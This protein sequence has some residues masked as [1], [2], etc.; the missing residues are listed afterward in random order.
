[1][2]VDPA[3][4]QSNPVRFEAVRTELDAYLVSLRGDSLAI[5]DPRLEEC[6]LHLLGSGGFPKAFQTQARRL[7]DLARKLLDGEADPESM[8]GR[9]SEG[10]AKLLAAWPVVHE[11]MSVPAPP[12]PPSSLAGVSSMGPSSDLMEI[13]LQGQ[14]DRLQEFEV[15]CLE[16]EKGNPAAH[17]RI[18][19]LLHNLKG[20]FGVLEL[21]SWADLL[22]ETESALAEDR[23]TTD[24]L[25]ALADALGSQAAELGKGRMQPVP[26]Q[27]L[28]RILNAAPSQMPGLAT[29]P[30]A[31]S[32]APIAP[33][34]SEVS[35]GGSL[36]PWIQDP[37]FLA[38]FQ[39]ES[40]E[41]I[42][43]IEIALL[44][45]ETDSLAED[46]LHSAFR[47]F[48]TIKGLAA[49]LKLPGIRKLSHA[50]ETMLDLV[51]RHEL[52]LGPAHIDVLLIAT[53]AL[54]VAVSALDVVQARSGRIE[55]S[56]IVPDE[57]M[58]KLLHPETIDQEEG[59]STLPMNS[60]PLGV[61]LV[62]QGT[63]SESTIGE[64]LGLQSAGDS[65]PLGEILVQ[66][67]HL[68]AVDV[69]HALGIQTRVRNE[70]EKSNHDPAGIPRDLP[71]SAAKETAVVKET[72]K[73]AVKEAAEV[74]ESPKETAKEAAAT[75]E[76]SIRVPVDRLDQ[77]IDAIGES[78][79]SQS[80]VFADPSLKGVG[81]LALEK[82]MAQAA[83]MLRRIQELSMSLRMV[84]IRQTFQKMS[85][86]V[87][88]LSRRQ[89]K[90]IDLELEGEATELDK[91][92][93]ENIG[94][95]LVHMVRNSVDHAIE[96]PEA[97]VAAGKSERGRIVLRAFHKAGNV[98]LEIE[99]DGKGLNRERILAKAVAAGIV[100][101][102]QEL[103]DAEV[104]RLIFHP[105]LSTAEK[106]TD[107]SGRGV[108]MDVV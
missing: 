108:G 107:V 101:P 23:I 27:L 31:V 98:H 7:A 10:L 12:E 85:R 34:D 69:G 40:M 60:E 90:I 28:E 37:S 16:R 2:N 29:A 76:D 91:T 3:R 58:A 97:R 53:D 39:N 106:V 70:Q 26:P 21:S 104:F 64:A 55:P 77:L 18:L 88:D 94:D 75:V 36:A 56:S 47:A 4:H 95:P 38:D 96:T 20:E 45:L 57:I 103:P 92:V 15:L 25:L 59:I 72:S 73:E 83:M 66:D 81:D 8:R 22:H 82:K 105:G 51:R 32:E 67:M 86:L 62:R 33:K 102:G 93:V 49:F 65:R 74:K 44:R 24:V 61:M 1:M 42:R 13:F 48:H 68:K 87:R 30:E 63:A 6:F 79:I 50:S 5:D 19:G 84:A 11:E 89:G 54:R 41:H 35:A 78:V 14:V 99:D 46:A 71:A 9:M 52:V 17:S 100:K 80:M 43:A